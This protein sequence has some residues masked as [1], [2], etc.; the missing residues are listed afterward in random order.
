[1]ANPFD[2]FDKPGQGNPFNQFDKQP[3][4]KEA[5]LNVDFPTPLERMKRLGRDAATVGDLALTLGSAGAAEIVS[6]FGGNISM[7]L[8][9]GVDQT[10]TDMDFVADK[11]QVGPFTEGGQKA[12]QKIAPALMKLEEG[13]DRVSEKLGLGN[14]IAATLIKTTLLGGL[15][16]ALPAKGSVKGLKAGAELRRYEKEIRRIAEKHGINLN[17]KQFSDDIVEAANRMTPDE[18][19]ANMPA[20]REALR[21]EKAADTRLKNQ[22]FKEARQTRT[23]VETRA[24]NDLQQNILADLI[25]DGFDIADMPKLQRRLDEMANL[26]TISV[27]T[28]A[29][30]GVPAAA[31]RLNEL[32]L[33]RQRSIRNKSTD[34]PENLA[35]IKLREGIDDFLDNEFNS[36]A[37]EAGQQIPRGQGAISGDIAGVEAWKRARAANVRWHKRYDADKVIKQLIEKEATPET[38]RQW[39]M[40]ASAMNANREAGATIR[41]MKEIMGDQHPVIEGIRQDFLF[42]MYQ[43]LL[44]E[45]PDFAQFTRNYDAMVL[46][47]PSL[48]GQLGLDR[49]AMKDMHDFARVQ[50]RLPPSGK[51]FTRGDIVTGVT[52]MVVGHQIAKAAVRVE[53]SRRLANALTGVDAVTPKQIIQ[54]IMN[55]KFGE[56]AIPKTSPLAAEFIAGAALTG[57]ADTDGEQ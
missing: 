26:E 31:V 46:R 38:Y 40:G 27:Q 43:P 55:V 3:E 53:F 25:E 7:L 47:N 52:R 37:V 51:I 29:E 9:R 39:L 22:A 10:V 24:V 21:R 50:A 18:R 33:I 35:L 28:G 23:F 49:G 13:A 34:A 56:V 12:V 8:G 4:T 11:L 32:E 54:D 14:P 19:A 20:L 48:V 30:R 1:M 15:E 16:L 44:K 36:I 41:R 5:G 42:E 45:I 57:A 17:L 6:G 2:K